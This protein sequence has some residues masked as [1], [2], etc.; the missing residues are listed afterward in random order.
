MFCNPDIERCCYGGRMWLG[1]CQDDEGMAQ[2]RNFLVPQS[3]QI[4]LVAGRPFF[5]VTP[6]MLRES[7][8]ALHFTQ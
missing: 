3:T 5:M 4:D 2:M 7:V 1:C 8:L 6:R